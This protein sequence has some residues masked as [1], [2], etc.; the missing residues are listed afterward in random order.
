M[1]Q[2]SAPL[3]IVAMFEMM[4][5][6]GADVPVV[7]QTILK[8][9][10]A[11]DETTSDIETTDKERHT[12]NMSVTC[13]MYRPSRRNDPVGAAKQNSEISGLVRRVAREEGVNENEFLA[14]V[15]QES[16]FNPCAEFERRCDRPCA[17]DARD[18]GSARCQ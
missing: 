1:K 14:L 15:Y 18:G 5:I 8:A 13:S 4:G 3:V 17:A 9:D 12:I 16:R 2:F 11:R 10:T 7:D 6:A